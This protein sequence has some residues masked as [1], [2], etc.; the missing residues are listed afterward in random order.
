MRICSV[1]TLLLAT[2]CG[3][4]SEPIEGEDDNVFFPSFRAAWQIMPEIWPQAA[5]L[6]SCSYH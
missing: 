5:F 3:E 4:L 6:T 1:V 2:G